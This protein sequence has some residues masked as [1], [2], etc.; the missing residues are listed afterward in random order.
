MVV[1]ETVEDN[2]NVI[3][4]AIKNHLSVVT[5]FLSYNSEIIEIKIL[6]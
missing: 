1:L 6:R 2:D 5:K 4:L 3:E